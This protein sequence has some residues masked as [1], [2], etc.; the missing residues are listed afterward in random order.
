MQQV[1]AERDD[2]AADKGDG[3]PLALLEP[4]NRPSSFCNERTMMLLLLQLASREKCKI[5]QRRQ[6]N[7]QQGGPLKWPGCGPG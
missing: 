4:V 7:A 6:L 1:V 5:E 2:D 3:P